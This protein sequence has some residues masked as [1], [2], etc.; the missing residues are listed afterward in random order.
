MFSNTAGAIKAQLSKLKYLSKG[1]AA[2]PPLA[3]PLR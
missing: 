2:A 1:I 3:P